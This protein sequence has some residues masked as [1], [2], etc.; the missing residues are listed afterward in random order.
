MFL[1]IIFR[2][3][4]Y[5]KCEMAFSRARPNLI[6]KE[7]AAGAAFVYPTPFP[8]FFCFLFIYQKKASNYLIHLG[9]LSSV[10]T[11]CIEAYNSDDT[12]V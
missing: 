10:Y 5:I 4:I 7:K 2:L 6:F 11:L 3:Q 12:A 8:K 9:C 1:E